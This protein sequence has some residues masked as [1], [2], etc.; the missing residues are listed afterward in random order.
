VTARIDS[1]VWRPLTAGRAEPVPYAQRPCVYMGC[2]R[3]LSEHVFPVQGAGTCPCPV[4][5]R[6][7]GYE[8]CLCGHYAGR[9]AD[10]TGECMAVV[11]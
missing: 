3:P 11:P 4:F 1:H 7:S 8:V 2:D 10:G 9:H 6:E 5:D